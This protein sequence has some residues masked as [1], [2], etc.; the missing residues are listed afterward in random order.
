[1]VLLS[2]IFLQRGMGMMSKSISQNG[3][4]LIKQFEGCKLVAYT[5]S[6]GVW[7]IGYG[8]TNADK[9]ILGITIKDGLR[10]TQSQADEWLKKTIEQS[11]LPK[12]MK[13]DAQYNWSQNEI[14]ALTSFCYNIGSID[15]L[16]QN[17]TR[18]RSQISA[19]ILE[20]NKAGGKVLAGLTN[21]RNAEKT[22]FDMGNK[23]SKGSDNMALSIKKIQAKSVSY[24][25]S[26]SLSNIRYIVI[27]YTGGTSDTAE[28]EGNYFKNSNTRSAGAH[29]FIDQEGII[30]QSIDMSL[31]AWSVGGSKYSDCSKTGGG[32][33]Y[34]ICTNSN[35][36]SIELCAI[37]NK[38]PSDKMVAATKS[39]ISYIQK[40][41]PNAKSIIRH[42]DV[43]G[44]SCPATM[45]TDATWN[46]FLKRLNA[47][48]VTTISNNESTKTT[49]NSEIKNKTY[50]VVTNDGSSLNIRKSG[51]ANSDKIGFIPNGKKVIATGKLQGDWYEVKYDNIT[52]YVS[53]KY[54]KTVKSSSSNTTSTVPTY[55]E[56]NVYKTNV[57]SLNIRVSPSTSAS[58]KTYSQLSTNAKKY[59]N[60]KGQL[61]KGT[62][63][64]CKAT[65]NADGY[66]WMQIPSGW[67]AAYAIDT[68]KYYV[69]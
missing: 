17:G 40:S 13:Y 31:T 30:V 62:S 56:G 66:V 45:T 43:T 19:K 44:K 20:Y 58:R 11:Y 48:S 65:K 22:L 57:D 37:A 18:T 33:L 28:N 27:H 5:D 25:G 15:Q 10:I 2:S 52:G 51:N 7:T 64:T 41:C 59:A 38:S 63:V 3:I 60:S 26:R 34:G 35:S 46:A 23:D 53:S 47:S 32:K 14:D 39:L 21:R 9:S 12:V 69:K 67:I 16:T 68:K 55:K 61:K 36:V 50:K 29:F 4:N 42:F 24:G 6:V 54:L 49:T 8:N 1:M